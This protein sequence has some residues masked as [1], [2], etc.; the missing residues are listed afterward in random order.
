VEKRRNLVSYLLPFLILLSVLLP[1]VEAFDMSL[2]VLVLALVAVVLV[3]AVVLN[4]RSKGFGMPRE[5]QGIPSYPRVSIRVGRWI[6]LP[7]A[8][9]VVTGF[10]LVQNWWLNVNIYRSMY[11]VK[12]DLDWWKVTFL[13]NHYF[14]VCIALGLLI[15][16]SDPRVRIERDAEGRRRFYLHSKTWGVISAVRS[17]LFELGFNP[18]PTGDAALLDDRVT[19]KKGFLWKGV[20][21]LLGAVVIGPI[22]ARDLALSFLLIADYVQTQSLSWWGF[23]QQTVSVLYTALLTQDVGAGVIGTTPLGTWLIAN[24]PVLEF[25]RLLQTPILVL[26]AFWIARLVVTALFD[27][28]RG[29]LVRVFRSAVLIG[30]ILTV[31]V[32]LQVPTQT[33][34]VTTPFYVRTMVV[35]VAILAVLAVFLSLKS[36]WVEWTIG[37]IFRNRLILGLLVLLVSTS[38]MY[39]PLVVAVQYA[40][41]MQGNWENWLWRPKFLPNVEYT[42]WATGLERIREDNVTSALNTGENLETLSRVRIFNDAASVLRL[43]PS[44]GVN[45]MD[46]NPE[47]AKQVDIVWVN[48]REYWVAPLTLVLPTVGGAEDVW[49]SERMLYTHSERVLAID[50]ASGEIVPIETVFNLTDPVSLY[51]GEGGLYASSPM[52]YLGIPG[53]AETHLPERAPTTFAGTPDYTLT[54]FE[55]FWFF[56]GLSGLE[57]LRWDFGRGDWGDVKML[58]VRDVNQRV[59]NLLLP[60]M[61]IDQDP[62]LVSDGQGVYFAL[63][64]Y[65]ERAMPTQYLDYPVN[66]DQFWRLFGVVLVDAYTGEI[67]GH[68]LGQD[69]TNYVVDFYRRM[70]PQWDAPVPDWLVSQLRYPEF[71]FERQIDSYNIY[72]VSNPDK[73]QKSSDFFEASPIEDVRYVVITFN[74]TTYWAGVRLV[75][76][77]ES[78]GQN[79]AAMYMALNG[80]NIGDVFLLRIDDSAVI[81]P[82]TAVDSV[83]NTGATKSLLT[84][85]PNWKPGNILMYVLNNTLYYYIPYYAETTT[86]LSPVMMVTVDAISQKVG[87]YVISNPQDPGEVGRAA[88]NAY[89]N[90]VGQQIELTAE[91]RKTKVLD[92]LTRRGY[93]LRTPQELYPDASIQAAVVSY[94]TDEAWDETN[95]TLTTFLE[96]WAAPYATTTILL[97]ETTV[98]GLRY[99]EIGVLINDA[100]VVFHY[101]MKIGYSRG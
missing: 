44:I 82:Q 57:G 20:E 26:G 50:A 24:S 71:L 100:G 23:I 79:L 83:S 92:E 48:G 9:I 47:V 93:D 45:W 18:F 38:L 53:F 62:Y 14:Y 76:F 2:I 96:T 15:V 27:L 41:A 37:R 72:H 73:W 69:E 21:F 33:F 56:S 65:I 28:R 40:P 77:F 51:Y 8:L 17:Q 43:K 98:G 97:R 1:F 64:V 42:Q 10:V 63:Y 87:Y 34:D 32:L 95:S 52:V 55:R 29:N 12:A 81:G 30:L 19:L 36:V 94:F 90:L 89:L 68:L 54:G 25:L 91:A 5:F 39:G 66:D 88:E 67:Q 16:V 60:G 7:V 46:F 80:E 22:V 31:P 78:P 58:Y 101:F 35:G 84:L 61:I 6:L 75:E 13:N 85:N 49:R 59:S 99:L 74:G 4:R 86:T 3:V 70:Y 11:L